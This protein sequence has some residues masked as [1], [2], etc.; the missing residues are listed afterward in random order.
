MMS[1]AI[2]AAFLCQ[3]RAKVGEPHVWDYN[4]S[5]K[6]YRCKNCLITI[7]KAELKELTDNA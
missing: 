7:S 6:S 3:D 1:P 2:E 5:R 4:S